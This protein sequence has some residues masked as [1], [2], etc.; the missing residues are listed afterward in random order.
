MQTDICC[1]RKRRAFSRAGVPDPTTH[2]LG[3]GDKKKKRRKLCNRQQQN[4]SL[5]EKTHVA[6]THSH[7]PNTNMIARKMS[8]RMRNEQKK[9]AKGLPA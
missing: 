6:M 7:P 4:K 3:R 2:Q 8:A 9:E 5:I 1:T